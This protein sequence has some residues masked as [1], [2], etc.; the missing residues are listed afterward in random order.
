MNGITNLT[1]SLVVLLGFHYVMSHILRRALIAKMGQTKFI[2]LFSILAT[3]IFVWVIKAFADAPI[4][5]PLWPATDLLW[6]IATVLMLFASIIFVGS[7]FGNPSV[8]NAKTKE[9]I[10]GPVRGVFAITRHPMMW[11][12]SIWSFTHFLVAPSTKVIILTLGVGLLAMVGSRG[13]E[14]RKLVSIGDAWAGWLAKTSFVPFGLQLRGK[15]GWASAWPGRRIILLG[16]VFWLLVS[17]AH[18]WFG[19]AGAGIWRWIW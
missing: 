9:L 8:P 5:M 3:I 13:Q 12:F 15:A 6:W 7:L 16:T 14:R 18:G 17:Y 11:G 10:E 1:A 4:S 19:V 2:I